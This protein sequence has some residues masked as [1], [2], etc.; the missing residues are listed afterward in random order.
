MHAIFALSAA[1]LIEKYGAYAGLA[2][3]LGLAVLSL[4]FFAQAREV[5]RLR[6]LTERQPEYDRPSGAYVHRPASG[7]RVRVVRRQPPPSAARP[8]GGAAARPAGAPAA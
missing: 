4:L 7:D 8:A 3:V 6:E 2:A 1:G 5:R